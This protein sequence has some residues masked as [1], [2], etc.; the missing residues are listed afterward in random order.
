MINI[1]RGKQLGG[2]DR[3]Q[4]TYHQEIQQSTK[5]IRRVERY[6]DDLTTIAPDNI[7]T[8]T[9]VKVN[10]IQQSTNINGAKKLGIVQ[11]SN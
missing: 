7:A 3:E 9:S 2:K 11:M 5:S 10:K 6:C 4:W 1:E 8:I